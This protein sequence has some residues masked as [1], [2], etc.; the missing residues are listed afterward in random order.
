MFAKPFRLLIGKDISRDTH[1]CVDGA[2]LSAFTKTTGIE[3]GEILVLDKNKSILAAGATIADTSSIYLCQ[4][5]GETY[6]YVD[7]TGSTISSVRKVIFSPEIQGANVRKYVGKSYVAKAE[8]TAVVNLTGL[9][10]AVNTE[11]LIRIIYKDVKEHP[12]QF[13]QTY[14][15]VATS[16]TLKTLVDNFTAIINAH[17]GRRVVCSDDDSSITLTGLEIPEC[18]TGLSDIDA[19][20]MVDF[21][22]RFLYVDTAGQWQTMSS[23]STTVTYTGPTYGSGNWEQIR[24]LEKEEL[25]FLG[26][27][28][29]THWPIIAPTFRTVVDAT[30]DLIVIEHDQEY[31]SPDNQYRKK[32]PVKTLVAFVVPTTGNQESNVLDRLNPWMESVGQDSITL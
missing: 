32:Q 16:A 13:T 28:N 26:V 12:G 23:T 5:T 4:G 25:G 20:S 24:D 31:L 18:T 2:A 1:L 21:E 9:T 11:Y 15:Q 27:T 10:P 8:K 19:F 6:S 14:R 17:K 29:Q 3:D 22:A 7:E 30:Y